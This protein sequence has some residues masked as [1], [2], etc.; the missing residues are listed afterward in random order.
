[1]RS[2]NVVVVAALAACAQSTSRARWSSDDSREQSD[3]TTLADKDSELEQR[4]NDPAIRRNLD[5]FA[6]NEEWGGGHDHD[7]YSQKWEAA[8]ARHHALVRKHAAGVLAT[9]TTE[10]PIVWVVAKQEPDL[11]TDV[12]REREARDPAF[13][14]RC[15]RA[16]K[17]QYDARLA[18]EAAA[19]EQAKRDA[20]AADLA[21]QQ[22]GEQDKRDADARAVV[23]KHELE[24]KERPRLSSPSLDAVEAVRIAVRE[25][26]PAAASTRALEAANALAARDDF[27][28]ITDLVAAIRAL[29]IRE[30]DDNEVI[31]ALMKGHDAALSARYDHIAD[32]VA[33]I[34]YGTRPGLQAVLRLTLQAAT[35]RARSPGGIAD[36]VNLWMKFQGRHGVH[37]IIGCTYA[38]PGPGEVASGLDCSTETKSITAHEGSPD[39]K[40]WRGGREVTL[41][42]SHGNYDVNRT[43]K[44]RHARGEA[45]VINLVDE[46][47][48]MPVPVMTEYDS[49]QMEGLLAAARKMYH[50][51]REAKASKLLDEAHAA[52]DELT[53]ADL[54]ARVYLLGGSDEAR[55]FLVARYHLP[56]SSRLG[57][58]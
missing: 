11:W 47:V 58:R 43:I 42:D 6:I 49:G 14:Q 51:A 33:A 19:K 13:E 57:V 16:A 21:A 52:T 34:G 25:G 9:V 50:A 27:D 2:W 40:E 23:A 39:K 32:E 44:V 26:V 18:A 22:K 24:A 46:T 55:V 31:T 7:H 54:F 15:G 20:V 29:P 37:E 3:L 10:C 12:I 4:W 56:K 36:N 38:P 5:L 48:R 53:K 41:S 1:M 8:V 30:A 17:A 35:D 45:I 28:A